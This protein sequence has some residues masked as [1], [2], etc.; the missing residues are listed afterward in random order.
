MSLF[1]TF[2]A[3]LVLGMRHAT[4]PDGLVSPGPT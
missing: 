3:S 4:D 2:A 1:L